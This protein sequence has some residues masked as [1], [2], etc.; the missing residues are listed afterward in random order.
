MDGPESFLKRDSAHHGGH[1]QIRT[2]FE[3]VRLFHHARQIIPNQSGACERD[4]V[5]H[6]MITLGQIRFHIVRKRVHS[7]AGGD[8]RRQIESQLRIGEGD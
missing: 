6:R 5:A 3:I 2:G 7:G 4:G 1:Q 8:V